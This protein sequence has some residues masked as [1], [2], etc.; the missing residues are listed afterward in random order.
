M[1]LDQSGEG[2]AVRILVR[3]IYM[4]RSKSFRPDQLFRLTE[5]KQLCY[6]STQ[7]PFISTHFSTDTLTSPYTA[8]YIPHS[9]FHLARL[10]YV[11][12]ETFGPYYVRPRSKINSKFQLKVLKMVHKEPNTQHTATAKRL[13]VLNKSVVLTK[14]IFYFNG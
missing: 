1:Q 11:R 4:V 6:F 7:S 3:K 2:S 14:H 5:I 10:L 9:I 13:H 12:P 8:L